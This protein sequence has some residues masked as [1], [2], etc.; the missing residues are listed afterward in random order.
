MS[1]FSRLENDGWIEL[2]T[3]DIRD[4]VGSGDLDIHNLWKAV[5]KGDHNKAA[6]LLGAAGWEVFDTLRWKISVIAIPDDILGE[7][8]RIWYLPRK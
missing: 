8:Y 4:A 3:D 5:G 7:F 2:P 1:D 6:D